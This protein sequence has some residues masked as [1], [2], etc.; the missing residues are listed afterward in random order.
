[1]VVQPSKRILQLTNGPETHLQVDI[2]DAQTTVSAAF[3]DHLWL[4]HQDYES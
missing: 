3:L 4:H 2:Q 1:M